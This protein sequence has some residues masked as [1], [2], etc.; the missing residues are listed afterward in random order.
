[1]NLQLCVVG[2][3]GQGKTTLVHTLLRRCNSIPSSQPNTPSITTTTREHL[4]QPRES[5]QASPTERTAG[6]DVHTLEIG[7]RQKYRVF[8]FAGH[9]QFLLSHRSFIGNEFSVYLLLLNDNDDEDLMK[10]QA[11]SWMSFVLATRQVEYGVPRVIVV[12]SHCDD[13]RTTS[14]KSKEVLQY[15]RSFYDGLAVFPQAVP[16]LVDCRKWVGSMEKLLHLLISEHQQM[17]L[18]SPYG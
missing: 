6:V 18:V 14:A 11:R 16:F 3:P 1:M 9:L 4:G 7:Q 5:H 15:L 8:D 17:R 13:G 12:I 10:D 2:N